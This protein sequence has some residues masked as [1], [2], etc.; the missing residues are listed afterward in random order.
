V[1]SLKHQSIIVQC[2]HTDCFLHLRYSYGHITKMAEA[3]AAAITVCLTPRPHL[4]LACYLHQC[5]HFSHS[6]HHTDRL[7][8]TT[9]PF[10]KYCM[11]LPHNPPQK[12]RVK[13]RLPPD[14]LCFC[15]VPETLH[16][17]VLEKM[18]APPKVSRV[19]F[20]L[21]AK[22]QTEHNALQALRH[23]VTFVQAAHPVVDHRL[24]PF[25]CLKFFNVLLSSD[26]PPPTI[27]PA[28]SA[29]LKAYSVTATVF[30]LDTAPALGA[31]PRK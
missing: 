5:S 13:S 10:S 4:L 16:A 12:L 28:I 1:R 21:L 22:Q 15:Q 25:D 20:W 6:L 19:R 30:C 17:S 18:Y 11:Q 9:R 31:W 3:M 7:L 26:S 8:A 24:E 14:T 29:T 23:F 2:C 27:T